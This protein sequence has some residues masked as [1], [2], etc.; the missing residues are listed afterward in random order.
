MKRCISEWYQLKNGYWLKIRFIKCKWKTENK[1]D[2]WNVSIVVVKTKRK[3]ND[4]SNSSVRRPKNLINKSTNVRGGIES[5]M[6]TLHSIL[7]FEKML[8][9]GSAIVIVGFEDQREKVYSRLLRY[10]YSQ[11]I[12]YDPDNYYKKESICYIKEIKNKNKC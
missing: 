8:S 4:H 7:Q 11:M 3:A 10:G 5:L 1:L 6:I 2:M 9:E 12:W